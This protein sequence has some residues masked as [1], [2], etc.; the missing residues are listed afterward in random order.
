M[1]K[2]TG[3]VIVVKR[4]INKKENDHGGSW[5]IAYA[6]FMTVMMAFFLVMWLLSSFTS[7]QRQQIAEYFK[8]P[9]K[10]GVAQGD[11]ASLSDSV[12][13][14]GG[15]DILKKEGEVFKNSR[16]KTN[17]IKNHDHLQRVMR[18]LENL[19]KTDPHL[20]NFISNLRLSLTDDGLL[21]QIVDSQDRP[22][23]KV[24]SPVPENYMVNILRALVEV[25]NEL[26]NRIIIT[27][28]TDSLPYANGGQGYSNWEL[29]S[30][31]AN[32]SRRIL[33]SHGMASDKFLRVIGMADTM[34]QPDTAPGAPINRRIS[35]LMLNPEEEQE[36][37]HE[38]VLLHNAVSPPVDVKQDTAAPATLHDAVEHVTGPSANPIQESGK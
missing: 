36:I 31:R 24:G 1:N 16:Q 9:I 17:A 32:A 10:V 11:K 38:D 37:L 7:E 3:K 30:D 15:D 23:F 18:R 8:M 20:S 22:M 33:V 19:I 5:K 27:G 25:L 26:P 14:G 34:S 35:I 28:H 21:I 12:I 6:D 29:S 4:S 13:P 2:R